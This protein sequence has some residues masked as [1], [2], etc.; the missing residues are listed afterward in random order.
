MVDI[1]IL[2]YFNN[3]CCYIDFFKIKVRLKDNLK[4]IAFL[5]IGAEINIMTRKKIEDTKE[6]MR[7][8]FKIEF[9][10]YTGYS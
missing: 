4:F 1:D 9:V 5:N 8:G 7:K 10:S 2:I 3:C 6:A